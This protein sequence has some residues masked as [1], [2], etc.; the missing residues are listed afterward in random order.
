MTTTQSTE[1]RI[2]AFINSDAV[3]R[4]ISDTIRNCNELYVA[5]KLNIT[6]REA[7]A[8]LKISGRW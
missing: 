5:D 4:K 1:A 6:R 7:R 8:A 3:Q 2:E